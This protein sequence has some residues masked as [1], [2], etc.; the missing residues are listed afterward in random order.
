[1]KEDWKY[2]WRN[3]GRKLSKSKEGNDIRIPEAWR[4][5]NQLN[6]NKSKPRQIIKMAK[7]NVNLDSR[8]RL[9]LDVD[10]EP[11]I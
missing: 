3:Y 5:P 6:T 4:A 7:V 11:R 9:I 8:F 1:M 2:I 10:L